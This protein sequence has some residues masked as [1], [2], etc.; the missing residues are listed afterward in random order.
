MD[1]LNRFFVCVLDPLLSSTFWVKG[2][3]PVFCLY[4]W[5]SALIRIIDNL[6]NFVDQ[7]VKI[8][9]PDYT[10]IDPDKAIEDFKERIKHYES[11]YEPLE[12][13]VDG[14]G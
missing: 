11:I 2:A 12:D 6:C 5:F 13:K 1:S 3:L 10:N 14:E 8:F 9:T 7:E 4:S